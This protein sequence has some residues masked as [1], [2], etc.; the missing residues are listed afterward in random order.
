MRLGPGETVFEYDV[1]V[2]PTYPYANRVPR[3]EGPTIRLS[4]RRQ[5]QQ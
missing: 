5:P 4:S 3:V 1:V 2:V